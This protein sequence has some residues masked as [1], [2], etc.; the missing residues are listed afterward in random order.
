MW[1]DWPTERR[2]LSLIELQS[3]L[4][5]TRN[6]S[7]TPEVTANGNT[8]GVDRPTNRE[9]DIVTYRVAIAAF[10]TRI[11]CKIVT[12]LDETNLQM[13]P[14]AFMKEIWFKVKKLDKHNFIDYKVG[15]NNHWLQK[16]SICSIFFI[17]VRNFPIVLN[18]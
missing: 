16:Y 2:T 13:V 14:Q 3:Q 6:S 5:I 17:I 9:T 10:W 7:E 8:G 4:K 12:F 11:S 1:T 15:L 18:L